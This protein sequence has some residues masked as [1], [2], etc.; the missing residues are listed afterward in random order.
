MGGIGRILIMCGVILVVTGLLFQ[1]IG[2]VPG[3]GRLPGDIYIK[4]GSMTFY[5][6][7]VTSLVISVLLSIILS[8][9]WKR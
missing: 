1:L 4:R 6:P 7:V 2:K 5:F 9:F 8:F 3:M